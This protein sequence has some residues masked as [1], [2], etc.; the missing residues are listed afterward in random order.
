MPP[1]TFS[2]CPVTNALSSEQKKATGACHIVRVAYISLGELCENSLLRR[3]DMITAQELS[4]LREC[5]A[6]G[7]TNGLFF[8]AAGEAVNH[9]L[10]HRTIGLGLTDLRKIATVALV[11]GRSKLDAT[12]GFLASGIARGLIIDG[13][14]ALEL[15]DF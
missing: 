7:D 13:D 1:S 14:T 3:Q 11:A 10:N 6:V 4:E 9:P 8:N 12:R 15:A 5:G 2:V